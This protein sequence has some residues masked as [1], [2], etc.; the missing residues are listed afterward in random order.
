MAHLHP[1]TVDGGDLHPVQTDG[2]RAVGRARA[3]DALLRPGRI[4]PRVHI[5]NAVLR[6]RIER[7]CRLSESVV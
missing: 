2:I 7:V 5:A 1:G 3:E 4:A 6:D